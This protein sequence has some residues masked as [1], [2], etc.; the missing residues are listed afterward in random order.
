MGYQDSLPDFEVLHRQLVL[1]GTVADYLNDR[2]G[3]T[4]LVSSLLAWDGRTD[5]LTSIDPN[6]QWIIEL[7]AWM[8]ASLLRA[9]YMMSSILLKP[10][11]LS[12][13]PQYTNPSYTQ[14]SKYC[15]R[16][17]FLDGNYTNFD[18]IQLLIIVCCLV[19]LCA[20]SFESGLLAAARQLSTF[21]CNVVGGATIALEE[22]RQPVLRHLQAARWS[23]SRPFWPRRR[24]E[25]SDLPRRYPRNP[26]RDPLY[27]PRPEEYGLGE[28]SATLAASR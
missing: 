15:S 19:L 20:L 25:L 10:Q 2:R 5:T 22:L 18:F 8:E 6:E 9:R 3:S 11:A 23:A 26:F 13:E 1:N 14:I 17:M 12:D 4:G 28:V 27:R 24:G 16:I 7:K 21:C